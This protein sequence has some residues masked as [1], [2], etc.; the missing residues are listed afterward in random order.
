MEEDTLVGQEALDAFVGPPPV[1]I[2]QRSPAAYVARPH[3]VLVLLIAG[4]VQGC[5][6]EELSRNAELPA[7]WADLASDLGGGPPKAVALAL[8][9]AVLRGRDHDFG[10]HSSAL[11][12]LARRMVAGAVVGFVTYE[13]VRVEMLADAVEI[14]DDSRPDVWQ[15]LRDSIVANS[16]ATLSQ[17]ATEWCG[18]RFIS[19]V[20]WEVCPTLAVGVA[21]LSWP[22]LHVVAVTARLNRR[23][24]MDLWPS[25]G[26]LRRFRAAHRAG[27]DGHRR[28]GQ[29]PRVGKRPYGGVRAE[30]VLRWLEATAYVKNLKQCHVAAAKFAKLLLP[31]RPSSLEEVLPRQDIIHKETLRR[32]RVRADLAAM[33]LFRETYPLLQNPCFYVWTDS[34]PQWKGLEYCASTFEL[35]QDG[36][37]PKRRL[38][39]CISLTRGRTSALHKTLALLWQ[40]TLVTGPSQVQNFCSCVRAIVTDMGSE[41]KIPRMPISVL[42]GFLKHVGSDVLVRL[43]SPWVFPKALHVP[44]WKHAVDLLLRKGL[45]QLSFFPDFLKRVKAIV[46]FLRD[47][48]PRVRAD[49]DDRGFFGLAALMGSARLPHFAN[50]RWAT[51]DDCLQAMSLFVQSWAAAFDPDIFKSSRDTTKL[52]LVT[53]ALS[54]HDFHAQL[55]TV[56]WY[57]GV[58][59]DLLKWGGGCRCHS[60]AH[61]Q[62]E[63]D[64]C[65]F[66][67]KL[68]AEAYPHSMAHLRAALEEVSKWNASDAGG[69]AQLL[70]Q[71]QACVRSTWLLAQEK[72]RHYDE[73]PYLLARLHEPGI[74]KRCLEQWA[75]ARPD[76]HDPVTVEF[77]GADSPLRA[78]VLALEDN[79]ANMS[80][81]LRRAWET[82]RLVPIDDTAGEG[83][84]A[85]MRHTQLK[86]RA[87]TWA[88]QAST[89]R[90]R[91]NL[92]DIEDLLPQAAPRMDFQWLWDHAGSI[93]QVRKG[94]RWARAMR[95]G[96]AALEKRVYTADQFRN[97]AWEG[98]PRY[99]PLDAGDG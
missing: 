50:W 33:L 96:R 84:H 24:L 25:E 92:A 97:F 32:A 47:D 8:V 53:Q 61:T 79:G 93:P 54:S 45:W 58:M 59:T 22:L 2:L 21:R 9:S 52:T 94:R 75:E 30:Q 83:P 1:G 71:L 85:S 82:M 35:H 18:R 73:L 26:T 68:L 36:Q 60:K 72:F 56:R 98:L 89:D 4:A 27:A 29:Q 23:R 66:K 38:L 17:L 13:V 67:G 12:S 46:S 99:D 31:G 14:R 70:R 40:I 77:L 51:L 44:G 80:A 19:P 20:P 5:F 39:P 91:Q 43:D 55:K 3:P 95:L 62:E 74:A 10:E 87:A 78:A 64:S 16:D 6:G 65:P 34:S 37:P 41:R 76:Q 15:R 88:W 48:M 63:R 69:D 90:L 28:R 7:E 57:T 86:A 81:D 11:P 42:Q 49:L